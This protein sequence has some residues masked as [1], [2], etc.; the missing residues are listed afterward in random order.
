MGGD[1]Y[2]THLEGG[3][4]S[5]LR[6][7]SILEEEFLHFMAAVLERYSGLPTPGQLGKLNSFKSTT[8]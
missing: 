5:E 1:S 3:D 2:L 7:F 6:F 8:I 4:A